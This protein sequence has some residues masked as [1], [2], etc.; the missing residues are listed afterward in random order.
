MRL[1][2]IHISKPTL[3]RYLH[4]QGFGS[5]FAAHKP[6]LTDK[7]IRERLRW[8][9]ERVNW[10]KEEWRGVV[11]SD[12]SRFAVE[13]YDG[14]ARVTRKAGERYNIEHIKS[15]SKFGQGSV[16]LWGCFWAGGFGPLVFVDGAMSQD[17]Y[18]NLLA[19]N[20]LP[21]YANLTEQE[22][23]EFIIQEDRATFLP[24]G[25]T[26]WWRDLHQI[27][28]LDK[29]PSNSPDL[30]PMEHVW[31]CLERLIERER[32]N[33]RNPQQLKATLEEAWRGISLDFC[34]RLVAS[35]QDRC[36]AVIDA[37]G[38]PTKY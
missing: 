32:G 20:F 31:A 27:R 11:W 37:K 22:D 35:M 1:H 6:N 30:N 8:A 16:M 19:E 13:G 38:G 25:Y 2:E 4:A 36:Q 24:D 23:R 29:W 18:V 9:K 3:V 26:T 17:A 12:E 10:T 34:E 5:Y 33:I 21:W 28:R 15:V 7:Q 14:G